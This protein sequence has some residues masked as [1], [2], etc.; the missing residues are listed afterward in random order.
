MRHEVYWNLHKRIWS[1]RSCATGRVAMHAR[2]VV[3]REVSFVVQP[4]GRNKVLRERRKNV[5]AFAR[6]DYWHSSRSEDASGYMTGSYLRYAKLREGAEC[7]RVTYNP[8]VSDQFME[9]ETG[10]PVKDA[11]WVLLTCATDGS[12]GIPGVR[13]HPRPEVWAC[14]PAKDRLDA[15]KE[16]W[17]NLRTAHAV[18]P[19][20]VSCGFGDA[21]RARQSKLWRQIVAT[22]LAVAKLEEAI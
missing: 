16:H 17:V 10:L 21:D 7:V 3:L 15:L 22:T 20:P 9:V 4:A 12:A 6:G 11:N 18:V 2:H 13:I 1:V 14:F 19:P 5:H 8:Y